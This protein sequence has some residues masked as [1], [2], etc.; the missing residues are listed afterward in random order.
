MLQAKMI[1][2][3]IRQKVGKLN[4]NERQL[5]ILPKNTIPAS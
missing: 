1:K 3:L 5:K 4:F 2:K